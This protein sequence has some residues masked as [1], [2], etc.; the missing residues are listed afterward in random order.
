MSAEV[1]FEFYMDLPVYTSAD[2]LTTREDR[3]QQS[4]GEKDNVEDVEHFFVRCTGLSWEYDITPTI[5]RRTLAT[6][7]DVVA[8]P[9]HPCQPIRLFAK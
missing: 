4:H 3:G 2:G 8:H 6:P 5:S 9:A 7:S 1:F